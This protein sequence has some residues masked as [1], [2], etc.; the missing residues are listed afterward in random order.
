MKIHSNWLRVLGC[1]AFL[2]IFS[3]ASA[4]DE[5]PI[6]PFGGAVDIFRSGLYIISDGVLDVSNTYEE[7][8]PES[9]I[10]F[11]YGMNASAESGNS[12]V[13]NTVS[14][15]PTTGV[16]NRFI[17]TGTI[18]GYNAQ[19]TGGSLT[20]NEYINSVT[21]Y[22][23]RGSGMNAGVQYNIIEGTISTGSSTRTSPPKSEFS[24]L[25][26]GTGTLSTGVITT[27]SSFTDADNGDILETSSSGY[28]QIV[29][30][31]GT[32]NAF[33]QTSSV[34]LSGA[35]CGIW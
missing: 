8:L 22:D 35:G 25:A 17:R 29:T 24:T 2:L 33:R 4:Q 1:V 32:I 20:G 23:E 7:N 31:S 21:I 14:S 27:N 30:V 13:F 28:N 16:G 10:V 15:Q 18:L 6:T 26:V 34:S 5:E 11:N 12:V 19:G 9:N 3:V